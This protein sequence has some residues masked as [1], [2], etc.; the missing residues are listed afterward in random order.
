MEF[1][2]I[3]IPPH[4]TYPV[5][6]QLGQI[7]IDATLPTVSL[8]HGTSTCPH[9][10]PVVTSHPSPATGGEPQGAKIQ[11]AECELVEW[12][13]DA[14]SGWDAAGTHQPLAQSTALLLPIAQGRA[15]PH[16]RPA[17]RAAPRAHTH[18]MLQCAG[19]LSASL[20]SLQRAG[21]GVRP[22][23]FPLD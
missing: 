19:E 14:V 8:H 12:Q 18:L 3:S 4:N 7:S 23:A 21:A 20:M 16:C 1:F 15:D 10:G 17:N 5:Y 9:T 13:A 11:V 6:V 2:C 22:A